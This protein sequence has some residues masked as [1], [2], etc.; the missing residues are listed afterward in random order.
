[1]AG[2]KA[3]AGDGVKVTKPTPKDHAAETYISS[4]LRQVQRPVEPPEDPQAAG[5][6]SD[7]LGY[8]YVDDYPA[9]VFHLKPPLGPRPTGPARDSGGG[10]GDGEDWQSTFLWQPVV[11]IDTGI[12][13]GDSNPRVEK[14]GGEESTTTTYRRPM[15]EADKI[16]IP[17]FLWFDLPG[18]SSSSSHKEPNTTTTNT[19]GVRL[20]FRPYKD[21]LL[22]DTFFLETYLSTAP[23]S[24]LADPLLL[25]DGGRG[26]PP[27]RSGSGSGSA[28]FF[29]FLPRSAAQRAQIKTVAV[30]AEPLRRPAP[31]SPPPPPSDSR[32]EDK[33][34]ATGAGRRGAEAQRKTR[35]RQQHRR[36][37][38]IA[39]LLVALFPGLEHVYLV[40][41]APVPNPQEPSVAT[42][43]SSSSP[44]SAPSDPPSN[45]HHQAAEFS[46][47]GTL[48]DALAA[49]RARVQ[50][51]TT[52]SQRS[53][54]SSLLPL[55]SRAL[56]WTLL[57]PITS[58]QDNGDHPSPTT[59]SHPLPPSSLPHLL[60]SSLRL[61]RRE[62]TTTTPRWRAEHDAEKADPGLAR[63]RYARHRA[64]GF[65][66]GWPV[67]QTLTLTHVPL[68][69][70][71]EEEGGTLGVRIEPVIMM[72]FRDRFER[73]RSGGWVPGETLDLGHLDLDL[74]LDLDSG[75]GRGL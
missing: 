73:A 47:W 46:K 72:Y 35:L 8:P 27:A 53:S 31:P 10:D 64:V 34:E 54:P 62:A 68:E 75:G 71:E 23:P 37:R 65:A 22:F 4:L 2:V 21:I 9:R 12:R 24:A 32:K 13:G 26:D 49:E 44:S 19:T 14:E 39:R 1:M 45:Q 63:R 55:H 15:T 58:H 43:S 41:M 61:A 17:H 59:S 29:S 50:A 33:D 20:G 30:S 7:S 28:S 3:T 74:D 36:R 66:R 52:S 25:L 70:D 38:A 60:T 56:E 57:S 67:R 40:E 42:S 5:A 18:G 69:D 51:S 6:Q 16:Y 11:P 48:Q